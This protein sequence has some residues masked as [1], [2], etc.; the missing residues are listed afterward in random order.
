MSINS[1]KKWTSQEDKTIIDLYGI[2][3]YRE[4]GEKL[5]R[6]KNSIDKRIKKLRKEGRITNNKI[7]KTRKES[8]IQRFEMMY[9]DFSYHSGYKNADKSFK[10]KCKICGYIQERNGQ[11]TRPK[12]IGTS[13]T[14]DKCNEIKRLE[15]EKQME[16]ERKAREEYK[17][18]EKLIQILRN[19]IEFIEREKMLQKVCN[20]CGREYKAYRKD[21]IHCD[22]C[23]VVIAQ[24]RKEFRKQW[25]GKKVEC[26]ECGKE[27]EMKTHNSKYCSLKCLNR[28]MYRMQ[29]IRKR[30]RLKHNGKIDN[31]ITLSKLIIRDKNTC[32][33]C[34]HA[35]NEKD[36]T[37]DNRGN[38]VVGERYPSIDHILPVSKGGTH[39][40]N[41][42]QL[43]HHQC[44][45]IKNNNIYKEVEGNGQ[46]RAI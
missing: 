8:F 22:E 7:Y 40:W 5:G 26:Y 24:E 14:C 3:T 2:K 4:I 37:I 27:F 12:F 39:T 28:A 34:G 10:S 45:S 15:N 20:R 32:K 25:E 17:V 31:S 11:C 23:L 29:A 46:L 1:G 38:F 43:A 36:Y 19:M 16:E 13:L 44:N 33:I 41:N 6:T 21:S 9:P 30:E 35:I 42:V 18:K